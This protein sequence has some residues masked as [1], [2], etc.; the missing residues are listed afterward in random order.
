MQKTKSKLEIKK[1]NLFFRKNFILFIYSLI[2]TQV[3]LIDQIK[4]AIQAIATNKTS[5][6]VLL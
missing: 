1:Q 6:I 3:L 4:I 5:V 2:K